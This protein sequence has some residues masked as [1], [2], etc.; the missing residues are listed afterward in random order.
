MSN[1]FKGL[2]NKILIA[3]ACEDN[4]YNICIELGKNAKKNVYIGNDIKWVITRPSS[5]PNYIWD[6]Q[7][8][9]FDV[10]KNVK[11]LVEKIEVGYVP[12]DAELLIG[13]TSYH[14]DYP[15][16]LK[17]Y[18]YILL[19]PEEGMFIDLSRIQ[20]DFYDKNKF[21]I[22]EFNDKQNLKF[23]MEICAEVFSG[24]MLGNTLE[25]ELFEDSLSQENT[26]FFIAKI[27]E[28][29]VGTSLLFISSGVA[30]VYFVTTVP[31]HRRKGIGTAMTLAP[32]LKAKKM[33]YKIGILAASDVGNL[34]YKKIG[35]KKCCMFDT[36][37]R[38]DHKYGTSI[39][40][41]IDLEV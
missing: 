11:Y 30:G 7:F 37:V 10:E 2:D 17:K 12:K 1:I 28:E 24:E 18:G 3:K 16:Y 27:G 38:K 29:I 19:R 25:I 32:L 14:S 33:G 31:G 34:V 5:W 9:K 20:D 40:I 36:Y 21:T 26:T 8:D 4:F 41:D 39:N 23:W 35:F 22:S 15:K 6:V 13:P